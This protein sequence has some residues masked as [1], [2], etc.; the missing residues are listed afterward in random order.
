MRN[1]TVEGEDRVPDIH[2]TTDLVPR[3]AALIPGTAPLP[4][5]GAPVIGHRDARRPDPPGD[6]RHDVTCTPEESS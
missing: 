5:A 4:L 1:N 2:V 3:S 6:P